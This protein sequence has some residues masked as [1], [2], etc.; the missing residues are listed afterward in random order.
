[1]RSLGDPRGVD[2]EIV[3]KRCLLRNWRAED[4]PRV[5]DIYSRWEVARWLGSEPR[6]MESAAEARRLIDRWGELNDRE[7][8][9]RR[10]AVAL[11]D[12]HLLG[13]LILVPLP[14]G[15]GEVEVGWHFHPDAWGRATPPKQRAQPSGGASNKAY[16]R[17]SR[18][19]ARTTPLRSHSARA[20]ACRPL[21]GP[22]ATTAASSSSSARRG[23]PAR[24]SCATTA[25]RC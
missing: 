17:S 21:A 25:A 8:L 12:G 23:D 11:P 15:A 5:F 19:S 2:V 6:A 20:S 4:E 18:W 22:P 3:T 14:D 9:A 24:L 7:P 13:T 16:R 1:M 10:W